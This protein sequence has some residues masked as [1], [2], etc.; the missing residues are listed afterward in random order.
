MGVDRAALSPPQRP[1]EALVNRRELRPD[2]APRPDGPRSSRRSGSACS[3]PASSRGCPLRRN[4]GCARPSSRAEA[5]AVEDEHVPRVEPR[6]ASGTSR[7]LALLAGGLPLC[8]E[9]WG[10]A[11][12]MAPADSERPAAGRW[13]VLSD[14]QIDLAVRQNVES[15]PTVPAVLATSSWMSRECGVSR[16][17]KKR[18]GP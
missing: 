18:S 17:G 10:L 3:S 15:A 7:W 2:A 11:A 13:T 6:R 5:P 4:P 12:M 14:E 9:N 1:S 16:L 8:G